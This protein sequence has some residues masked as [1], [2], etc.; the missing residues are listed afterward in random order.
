[1]KTG[2]KPKGQVAISWS[3]Q[4]AY[5]IGLL[6]ADGC[7]LNDGRH[8]DFTSKDRAQVATFKKCLKLKTKIGIKHSGTGNPYY[9]V[10]FSDV[11]FRKFLI[12]IGITPAKSKTISSVAIPDEYFSDFLR[13]YFDGD[14][15]SYSFYDSLFPKSYRFYVSFVSASSEYIQWLQRKLQ[16]TIGVTGHFSHSFGKDYIQLKFAKREAVIICN[17]MYQNKLNPCLKRK[18]LKIKRSM[19]IISSRR[20]GE[21][22]KHASFRS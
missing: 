4:F 5:A 6:T 17:Y 13:G 12:G 20:G 11:L 2:P 15:T 19:S 10:Q 8:I 9:R 22:G 1:M 18:Y 21:I 7:L 14:G 3:P 16:S